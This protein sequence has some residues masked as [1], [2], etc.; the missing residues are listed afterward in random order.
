ME[1]WNNHGIRTAQSRSPN[2]LFVEGVLRLRQSGLTALDFFEHID[3]AYGV[4]D[5]I[6]LQ[7]DEGVEIP[8]SN[9]MLQEDHYEELQSTV[10]PQAPSESYGID[11]YQSALSFVYDKIRSNP[12]IY[13][14]LA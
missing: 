11:L 9:F 10:D 4:E 7:D 3:E 1:G 8:Q 6:A 14:E 2:Q 13:G 12:L 5:G